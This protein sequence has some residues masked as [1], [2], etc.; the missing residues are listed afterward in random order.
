MSS[1]SLTIENVNLI[2]PDNTQLLLD[3]TDTT[4]VSDMTII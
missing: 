2:A 4:I 1:L 3:V